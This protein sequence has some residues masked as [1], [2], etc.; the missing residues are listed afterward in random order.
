MCNFLP[1]NALVIQ[2]RGVCN[3]CSFDDLDFKLIECHQITIN[4][5]ALNDDILSF[6]IFQVPIQREHSL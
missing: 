4:R 3:G 2:N 5:S 6:L 1:V